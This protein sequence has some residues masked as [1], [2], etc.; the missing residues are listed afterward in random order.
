MRRCLSHRIFAIVLALTRLVLADFMQ[1]PPAQ[2]A[3]YEA[4][5]PMMMAGEPCPGMASTPT[6]HV[7]H[8]MPTHDG[9]CCKSSQ[10]L[11]LHTPA[12]GVVLPMPAVFSSSCVDLPAI[13]VHRITDP[14]A[15][16]FRPPI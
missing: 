7:G 2:A 16:F 9:K 5:P 11:C 10:C 14:A 3:A 13:P 6:D 8:P 15:V 12:L 1:L 4:T